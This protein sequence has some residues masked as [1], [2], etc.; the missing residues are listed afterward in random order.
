M[1]IAASLLGPIVPASF[2]RPGFLARASSFRDADLDVDLSGARI[3]ITGGTSGIGL[4]A[5]T[6]LAARGAD[7]TLFGR[8]D[9]KGAEAAEKINRDTRNRATFVRCD[10]GD[11]ASVDRIARA[12]G[13]RPFDRFLHNASIL[14]HS[15]AFT[16]DGLE[17]TYATNLVGP[18]RL[19]FRMDPHHERLHRVVWVSSGGMYLVPLDLDELRGE[20]KRF[21]GVRAYAQTKRAQILTA[22]A[23]SRSREA[24][25]SV[26]SMHPGWVD[27]ASVKASLPRFYR[28]TRSLLR[29]PEQGA[30]TAVWLAATSTALTPGGF[31]FDR[32]THDF[33]LFPGTHAPKT[34]ERSLFDRLAKDAH[35]DRAFISTS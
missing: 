26:Y 6:A 33:E 2:G 7:V 34:L 12:L 4:A 5:A 32:E 31:Y 21:D 17:T 16:A 18:L 9:A 22:R 35:V 30:D 24:T 19:Q 8:D 28:L 13:P 20:T 15:R 11:F 3:G 25:C 10:V 27:T 14:T 23:M 29:T 1:N